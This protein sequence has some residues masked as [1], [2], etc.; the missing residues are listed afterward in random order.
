MEARLELGSVVGLDRLDPERKPGQN[1][2][3]EADRGRLGE[4]FGEIALIRNVPRTA[5][6]VAIGDVVVAGIDRT[7]FLDALTGQPRSRSIAGR[8]VEDRLAGDAIGT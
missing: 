4:G 7:P 6:V 1:L 5:M 3:E 8:L 2:V